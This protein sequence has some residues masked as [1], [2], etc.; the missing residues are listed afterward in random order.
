LA[1]TWK[2][3]AVSGYSGAIQRT[4]NAVVLAHLIKLAGEETV[5]D[6]VREI[7]LLKLEELKKWL[8]SQGESQKDTSTRAEFFFAQSQIAHFEENPTHIHGVAPAQP[9]AG[10]P[11]GADGDDLE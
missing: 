5:P 7:A 10:D 1:S 6:Q 11:I 3:P 9:P 2:A 4:M 8:A